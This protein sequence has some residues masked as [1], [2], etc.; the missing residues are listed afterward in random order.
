MNYRIAGYCAA[1]ALVVALASSF[2]SRSALGFVVESCRVSASLTGMAFPC[3]KVVGSNDPMR[4]YAIL[5]EPTYRERTI[6]TPLAAING[7]EDPRLLEADGPNYLGDAWN[8]RLLVLKG[9]P[10]KDPWLDAAVAINAET[11]RTQDHLHVHIGCIGN[12]L[13][14]ALQ[15]NA[16]AISS[17]RFVKMKTRLAWRV[18]FVKFYPGDDVPA[19]NPFKA[20]ADGVPDAR[21]NMADVAIGVVGAMKSGERGFY[22]LAETN[23]PGEES[24]GSAEDLVDPKC[25]S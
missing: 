11:N 23:R 7:I 10:A 12:R 19:I 6:L 24:Y 1:I 3:L 9:Y 13:K 14:S 16:A 22:V 25:R 15:G 5:H 17:D 4:A 20:V 18:F 8:E 21:Q 2:A